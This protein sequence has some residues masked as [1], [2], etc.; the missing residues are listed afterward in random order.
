MSFPIIHLSG[1]S[2]KEAE[3]IS[4]DITI[5][6]EHRVQEL[7]RLCDLSGDQE[8]AV[9]DVFAK[10]VERTYL[11]VDRIFKS[12]EHVSLLRGDA[13]LVVIETL[14]LSVEEAYSKILSKGGEPE[15][16]LKVLQIIVAAARPLH[17]REIAVVLAIDG[18]QHHDYSSLMESVTVEHQLQQEIRDL[19][20]FFVVI[21]KG[22]LHFLHQTAREFLVA[23]KG[24]VVPRWEWQYSVNLD[25]ANTV[26]AYCC[27][28]NRS[29]IGTCESTRPCCRRKILTATASKKHRWLLCIIAGN[30]T[31]RF[32]FG[33]RK[34]ALPCR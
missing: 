33:H 8:Q 27:M 4:K 11:W 30:Q 1:E 23:T 9:R 22:H 20:G 18:G 16:V 31:Q 29:W 6:I 5:V 21:I 28:Q 13:L 14:P 19:C 32:V 24:S 34:R 12:F 15:K 17:L 25:V 26:L 10:T 2:E 7:V 3:S